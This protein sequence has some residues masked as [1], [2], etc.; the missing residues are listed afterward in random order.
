MQ[1]S[2]ASRHRNEL[3][4]AFNLLYLDRSV[5]ARHTFDLMAS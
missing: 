5:D 3:L 4:Y 2:T 1:I